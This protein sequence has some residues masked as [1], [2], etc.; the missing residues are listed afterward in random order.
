MSNSAFVEPLTFIAGYSGSDKLKAYI[1][2][3]L[4]QVAAMDGT[5]TAESANTTYAKLK[6]AYDLYQGP[7]GDSL[8][9]YVQVVAPASS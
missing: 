4:K 1:E 5:V 9:T 6:A 3:S 7:M 2:A 8:H